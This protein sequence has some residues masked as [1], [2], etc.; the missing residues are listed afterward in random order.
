[1]TLR[2]AAVLRPGDWVAY[3]G[4]EHQVI[5]LAGTSVRL[6]SG[7]G[8]EQVVL[9]VHLMGSPGFAVIDG[10]PSPTVE[11]FGLLDSLPTTVLDAAREWERHVVEVETGLAP[12]S[13]P[14]AAPR[15]G[16][17]PATT[18]LMQRDEAKGRSYRPAARGRSRRTPRSCTRSGVMTTAQSAARFSG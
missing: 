14:G 2:E 3:D 10:V 11:P 12:G 16:Y 18:T 9:G 7:D 5:A 13:D 17:D 4:G 15:P 8:G 1:M 6:R